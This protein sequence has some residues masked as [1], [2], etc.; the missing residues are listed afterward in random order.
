LAA[1]FFLAAVLTGFF[2]AG[3]LVDFLAMS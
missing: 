3:D 1:G 2:D